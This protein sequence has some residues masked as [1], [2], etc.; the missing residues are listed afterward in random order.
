[1][2]R[3]VFTVRVA[4]FGLSRPLLDG[5]SSKIEAAPIP[6]KETAPEGGLVELRVLPFL[7]LHS[8]GCLQISARRIPS[9]AMCTCSP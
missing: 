2:R 1:M 8:R 5:D 3:V 4:D 9:K 6:I 7:T